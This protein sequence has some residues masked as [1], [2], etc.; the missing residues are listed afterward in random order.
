MSFILSLVLP[1]L[2]SRWVAF[3]ILA[4]VALVFSFNQG[5]HRSQAIC[6]AES[7]RAAQVAQA[8][9]DAALLAAKKRGDTLSARLSQ[10]ESTIALNNQEKTHEVARL[11]VGRP[12]FDARLVGVLNQPT[13]ASGIATSPASTPIATDAA[14]ATDQ[15]VGEW[16]VFAQGQYD[17]CRARLNA[18]IDWFRQ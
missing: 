12:C 3:A 4:A 5:A 6:Q 9:A 15:D 11:S 10:A 1:L 14:F 18:L 16:I 7:A 13:A 17:T 2:R 8:R